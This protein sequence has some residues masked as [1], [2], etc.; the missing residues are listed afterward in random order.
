M[1]RWQRLLCAATLAAA[2]AAAAS[3][4]AAQTCLLDGNSYPENAVVC[5]HGLQVQC[6]NGSWQG[7]DGTRCNSPTGDYTNSFRPYQ[8]K[9]DEPI[10]EYYL[11]KYPWLDQK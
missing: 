5:S 8:P 6:V 10:P 2:A 3:A 11:K 9:S 7:N 4:E 1:T